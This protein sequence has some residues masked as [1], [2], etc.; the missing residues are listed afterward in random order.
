MTFI[1]LLMLAGWSITSAMVAQVSRRAERR[2]DANAEFS[3]DTS[4]ADIT[5]ASYRI[6]S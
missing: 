5:G 2:A 4:K 1:Y 3:G 6:G